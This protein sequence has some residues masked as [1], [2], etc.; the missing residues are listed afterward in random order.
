MKNYIFILIFVI[1]SF[2]AFA[3]DDY[4]LSSDEIKWL[5]EYTGQTTNSVI[6][7]KRFKT[8]LKQICPQKTLYLGMSKKGEDIDISNNLMSVL[9]GPPNLVTIE[10]EIVIFSACRYHS[11]GEKGWVMID[12][13]NKFAVSG[14]IHYY[15]GNSIWSGSPSL[16]LF[17]NQLAVIGLN[18]NIKKRVKNWLNS[19]G[20]EIREVRF[21]NEKGEVQHINKF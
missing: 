8:L 2:D 3:K 16:L 4:S 10:N 7:D 19:E 1:V 21:L 11:C 17:S 13:K 5:K 15:Y 12:I 14:I 6:G 18:K 9:G 20:V